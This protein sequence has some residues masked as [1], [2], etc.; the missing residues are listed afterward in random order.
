[1]S[2]FPSLRPV[3][4][5]PVDSYM[6][7]DPDSDTPP[8]R[9][10]LCAVQDCENPVAL[11]PTGRQGK[12]C[13]EHGTRDRKPDTGP[14]RPGGR[15]PAWAKASEVESALNMIFK[16]GGA[17]LVVVNRVDGE[18]ITNGGPAVSKALVDLGRQDKKIRKY[19]EMLAAPGKYGPLTLAVASIAIPIM[20]NHGLIPTFTI[21]VPS[22]SDSRP[23]NGEH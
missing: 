6:I 8:N 7:P 4:A 20:A 12:Y 17:A 19:L 9:P 5:P 10:K 3:P 21:D 22:A 16:F 18:A 2:D 1:M 11:T 15:L 13:E 23:N 14:K